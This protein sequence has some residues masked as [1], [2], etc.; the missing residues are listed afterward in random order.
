MTYLF[1]L[2]VSFTDLTE[3]KLTLNGQAVGA[4][5]IW[6]VALVSG[7]LILAPKCIATRHIWCLESAT[8]AHARVAPTRI[9]DPVVDMAAISHR[10]LQM[11]DYSNYDALYHDQMCTSAVF[12][13]ARLHSWT[14]V[15]EFI[16]C[17]FRNASDKFKQKI[18]VHG[19]HWNEDNLE[20]NR[21]GTIEDVI[22]YCRNSSDSAPHQRRITRYKDTILAAM[23]ALLLQCCTTVATVIA[24]WYTPP[25]VSPTPMRFTRCA[26]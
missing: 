6:L 24:F 1:T 21:M 22:S 20:R 3:F 19:A 10:G 16:I 18:P 17:H 15:S 4:A 25:F 5:W 2:T 12:N 23:M 8:L 9:E 26:L 13:Y 14:R 7:W 11:H